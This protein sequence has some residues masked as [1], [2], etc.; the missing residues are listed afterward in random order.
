[1]VETQLAELESLLGYRFRRPDWLD[2]ALMHSSRRYELG[3]EVASEDNER[4]EFL[5]DAVL[6]LVVTSLLL[7]AFPDW[8]VGRLNRAKG[9]L[10]SAPSLHAVAQRLELGRFLQL[11]TGEEKTGGRQKPGLLSDAYEAVVAAI[12]LDADLEAAS[13]FIRRTLWE[14]AIQENVEL[15]GEPDAKTAL[16]DRL[17]ELGLEP[18]EYRLLEAIGPDH[19]KTFRVEVYA[20]GRALAVA[21]GSS[22]KQAELAAAR[23]ALARLAAG[24]HPKET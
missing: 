18:A 15:L 21:E 9:H 11:G 8:S 12:Y 19:C 1:M 24:P 16:S 7:A 5:G 17:R 4:L 10:V 20:E 6:G 2:R 13:E 23:I 22:K 14:Q 3:P